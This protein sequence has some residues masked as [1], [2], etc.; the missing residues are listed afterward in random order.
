MN[1]LSVDGVGQSQRCIAIVLYPYRQSQILVTEFYS[2]QDRHTHRQTDRHG[3]IQILGWPR[4]SSGQ[5]LLLLFV[6]A[7]D[8]HTSCID[9]RPA[10]MDPH[11]N[12]LPTW[13]LYNSTS[14][15]NSIHTN[16]L[17]TGFTGVV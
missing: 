4:A 13:L 6:T 2:G 8:V 3:R 9:R 14:V 10:A 7:E 5:Q 1:R 15:T 17:Q 12:I 11:T 16:Q